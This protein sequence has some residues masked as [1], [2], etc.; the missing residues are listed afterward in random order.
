MTLVCRIVDDNIL[1]SMS[2]MAIATVSK[3]RTY[4]SFGNPSLC[5]IL[6]RRKIFT[7]LAFVKDQERKH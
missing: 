6:M 2:C 4:N 3:T 7:K 1:F 5:G